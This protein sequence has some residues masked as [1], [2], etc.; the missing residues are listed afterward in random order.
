MTAIRPL[1]AAAGRD[2]P[3]AA[4]AR[5]D[6]VDVAVYEVP[7]GTEAVEAVAMADGT[8]VGAGFLYENP[9]A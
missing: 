9:L 8:L 3:P 5:G 2:D 6:D 7:A 1:R 4:P